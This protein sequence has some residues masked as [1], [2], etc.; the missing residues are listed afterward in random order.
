MFISAH[1]ERRIAFAL[2]SLD[3][4]PPTTEEV[5]QSHR[6]YLDHGE[7]A[8]CESHTKRVWME[9]TCLENCILMF[10]QERK[11]VQLYQVSAGDNNTHQLHKYSVS[12]PRFLEVRFMYF[13]FLRYPHRAGKGY[14]MRLAYEVRCLSSFERLVL[15][16]NTV[17][18]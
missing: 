1:K 2:K 3:R 18:S 14:L 4:V 15:K 17:L 13:T 5:E 10:P 11:W 12:I 9:D 8:K 16:S 6:L 7:N